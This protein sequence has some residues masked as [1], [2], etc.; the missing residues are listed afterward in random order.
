MIPERSFRCSVR[1][2]SEL[3]NFWFR[4]AGGAYDANGGGKFFP[5]T[6]DRDLLGNSDELIPLAFQYVRVSPQRP[7][8]LLVRLAQAVARYPRNYFSEVLLRRTP[9]WGSKED[10]SLRFRVEFCKIWMTAMA[11]VRRSLDECLLHDQAPKAVSCE[12]NWTGLTAISEK[13]VPEDY[14]LRKNTDNTTTEEG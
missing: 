1:H 6:N 10:N 3:T 12:H 8:E 4:A 14:P 2:V 11:F 7:E 5:D 13:V 9:M